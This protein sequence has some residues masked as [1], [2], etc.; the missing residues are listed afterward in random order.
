VTSRWSFI[1]QQFYCCLIFTV[2]LTETRCN[3]PNYFHGWTT[4]NGST[5]P[6]LPLSR[7]TGSVE[8]SVNALCYVPSLHFSALSNHPW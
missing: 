4:F 3:S 2:G 6:I 8:R 7:I 5:I 1:L